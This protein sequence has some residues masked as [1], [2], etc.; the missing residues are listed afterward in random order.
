MWLA[1]AAVVALVAVGVSAAI[2]IRH[3][4][5]ILHAQIVEALSRHFKARV[6]LDSFHVSLVKG[7]EAEGKGLR[8]WPPSNS[9]GVDYAATG[10]G[11]GNPLISLDEF[12]FHA[13]LHYRPGQPVVIRTVALKGLKVDMPPRVKPE[14]AAQPPEQTKNAGEQTAKPEKSASLL[15]GKPQWISFTVE[16][17]ECTNGELKLET[18]K[19]GK[20]PLTFE[21]AQLTLTRITPDLAADYDTELTNPKPKGLIHAQGR[22][23][24]WQT[25][26]P[27]DSPVNGQYTFQHADLSVFTGIA[28]ILES[29]G[30]FEGTLRNMTVDG[31]AN[32]PDFALTSFGNA[33]PLRTRF[34]A[35]VDGTNGD[36][37]LEP[38]DATLGHS[39]FTA[40]G[41]VV[42]VAENAEGKLQERG[43]DIALNVNVDKARIEDFLT[44][45]G[46]S[47]KPQLNG[48]VTVETKLHISPGKEP[49]E[50]R[51]ELDG[52]FHLTNAQFSNEDAQN[53]IREL[54]LRGQGKPG[55]LKK[56]DPD[57][58]AIDSAMSGKF[59]MEKSVVTLTQLQY[60]V[61]GVTVDLNGSFALEGGVV[62][63]TGTAKTQATVSQMVGGWK[64]FL[65]K[66]ADRFFKKDGAGA[67]VPIHID[68][69]REK[70]RFGVDFGKMKGTS[71]EKPGEKPQQQ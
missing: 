39:H 34:H 8:V 7:I 5:P 27:G 6:E 57:A 52:K 10:T 3:A 49:V 25:S 64:G 68:G 17:I 53:K 67:E 62:N 14:G 2:A 4:E 71:P 61:P 31:D 56:P 42:R 60:S 12:R 29:V 36:T 18:N 22:V 24:P 65:L 51:L 45:A 32:V 35:R 33:M 58:G 37:W 66:P 63:F 70:P 48:D 26:D 16:R 11:T 43:R 54:S 69:T 23:G 40:R 20:L 59:K 46:K 9:E 28:G 19:P 44:L 47:N 13:P 1:G 50:K 30:R 41:Q 38:V 21:I 55:E 15:L